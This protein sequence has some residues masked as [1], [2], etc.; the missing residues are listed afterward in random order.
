[1]WNV[2]D[3]RCGAPILAKKR[4]YFKDRNFLED[5]IDLLLLGT[6]LNLR[7]TAALGE[8]DDRMLRGFGW[9]NRAA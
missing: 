2:T 7:R 3:F 6:A 9:S 4:R 8:T 1:Q 5:G